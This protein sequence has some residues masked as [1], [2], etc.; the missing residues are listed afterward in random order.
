MTTL[1][2]ALRT[3]AEAESLLVCLDFD[4]TISEIVP[5]PAAARAH[6]AALAAIRDLSA[7]P[8][9]QVAVLSGRHLDG[10]RSVFPLGDPVVLVGSHGA[11]TTAGGP[12]LTP[13]DRAF[14]HRIEATLADIAEPPASVEVKPYQRVL[15]VAA[16]AETDP[17]RAESLLRRA[18]AI[19]AGGR[20]VIAGRNVVEFSALETTKGSWLAGYKQGFSATL[21]AGDDTTD[22]T[23]LAVLGQGDVGIKVG[24]KPSVAPLR[25]STVAEMAGVLTDL[26]AA[27]AGR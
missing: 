22:E 15:H 14:L 4:G 13:D 21:M 8:R 20:P 10:L 12:Q 16:L 27:R 6:P 7:L 3:L 23:A 25:V 5:D 1:D 24:P 18:L 17:G 2:L 11:E 9:T 26:A 19:D